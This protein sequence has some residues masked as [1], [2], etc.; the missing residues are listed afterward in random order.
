MAADPSLAV[1]PHWNDAGES[2]RDPSGRAQHEALVRE[3]LSLLACFRL[4]VPFHSDA[5]RPE[6]CGSKDGIYDFEET[7]G[8]G[9]VHVQRG[10]TLPHLVTVEFACMGLFNRR[11]QQV[12]KSEERR[13]VATGEGEVNQY[14]VVSHPSSLHHSKARS[15]TTGRCAAEPVGALHLPNRPASSAVEERHQRLVDA[16]RRAQ[17]ALPAGGQNRRR[18]VSEFCAAH[19]GLRSRFRRTRPS[20]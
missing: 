17:V 1:R 15:G 3:Q 6:P 4:A 8:I 2:S 7:V 20:G 9:A 11:D 19:A 14:G 5:S 16:T 13:K 10:L 12:L 18:M